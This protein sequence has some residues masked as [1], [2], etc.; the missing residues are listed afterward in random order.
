MVSKARWAARSA[1]WS[2]RKARYSS[3]D[4]KRWLEGYLW[5][6]REP[7]ER[8]RRMGAGTCDGRRSRLARPR[9]A[10]QRKPAQ[11]IH[12][13]RRPKGMS[14]AA[15]REQR[16][17]Q[18]TPE[19]VGS[20]ESTCTGWMGRAASGSPPRLTS[21]C[22]G[23]LSQALVWGFFRGDCVPVPHRSEPAASVG[24]RRRVV[25]KGARRIG[26][27]GREERVIIGP[28]QGGQAAVR[29]G[30]QLGGHRLQQR[31]RSQPPA[32]A[33]ACCCVHAADS[34]LPLAAWAMARARKALGPG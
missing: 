4:L 17:G 2:S 32:V 7:F 8:V 25:P 5:G 21:G 6:Q 29:H 11:W 27:R 14:G 34:R 28:G 9:A 30:G 3:I 15:A 22:V 10:F 24:H 19:T 13:R 33:M 26:R 23:S 20:H 18:K 12:D 1:W 16:S 31:G